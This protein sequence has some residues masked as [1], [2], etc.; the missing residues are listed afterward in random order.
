MHKILHASKAGFPCNRNLFYSVNGVEPAVSLK[1]Q[2]IF[3]TGSCLEPLV[4]LWLR[5]DDWNVDYNQGNQDAPFEVLVPLQGGSLA[6]H[7]DCFISKGDLLNVLVDI[8]TM[9]E[10]AFTLFKRDGALKSKPQYVT[11]LHVYALGCKIAGINFSKLGIIALNKNNSDWHFDFFDFDNTF[12]E[13]IKLNAEYIFSLDE[14]PTQN[15]PAETWCC[16]YCEFSHFC[17]LHQIQQTSTV[18]NNTAVADD[19]DILSAV[20]QLYKARELSKQ[21][22]KLETEA[23]STLHS[24]LWQNGI[25]SVQADN[26][27]LN[28]SERCSSRFDSDALKAAYPEIASQFYKPSTSVFYDIKSF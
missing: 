2:R 23:K 7:P 27:I 19:A 22:R 16:N 11:Q 28:I 24:K 1:S 6:G 9:N 26:I 18:N 12:A 3:D 8:K 17:N 20:Q 15:C 25:H 5:Q 10:R 21:A 4:V 13:N 14:P